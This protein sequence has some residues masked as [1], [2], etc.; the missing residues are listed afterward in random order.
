MKRVI[1]HLGFPKTGTT[2]LQ[3]ELFNK[4]N[5]HVYLGRP[6][7]NY[8]VEELFT[9]ILNDNETNF[10]AKASGYRDYLKHFVGDT[11][12]MI[13]NEGLTNSSITEKSGLNS[14]DV[15]KRLYTVFSGFGDIQIILTIRDQITILPSFYA[16][17]VKEVTFDE[18]IRNGVDKNI[19]IFDNL[20]Y[21]RILMELNNI[22][23][24]Q[25]VCCIRYEDL[26]NDRNKF[27]GK[28]AD[29]I[30]IEV[31][32]VL[33]TLEMKHNQKRTS[34]GAHLA[35]FSVL[36][37]LFRFKNRIIKSNTGLQKYKLVKRMMLYLK[38]MNISKEEVRLSDQQKEEIILKYREDNF[39]L[40]LLLDDG[41]AKDSQMESDNGLK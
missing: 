18:F 1:I 2:T 6:Y 20:Y 27:A 11:S 26:I 33:E 34:N 37:L 32:N 16:Q 8:E 4:L 40:S 19:S 5:D 17:F 22:F 30:G 10:S 29:A 13:S 12:I 15:F 39:K 3:N 14:K 9:S 36:D 41:S 35:S 28:L 21:S 31:S 38:H 25:N 23:G 7:V 24:D